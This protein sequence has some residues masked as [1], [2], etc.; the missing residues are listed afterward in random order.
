MQ[1]VA[2]AHREGLDAAA[3][4]VDAGEGVAAVVGPRGDQ[5]VLAGHPTS[6]LRD[7]A[8]HGLVRGVLADEVDDARTGHQ[9]DPGRTATAV[10]AR[11]AHAGV[12]A[13][14]LDGLQRDHA[15]W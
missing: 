10:A 15:A 14:C 7:R 1:S 4:L 13:G 6:G 9:R 12:D 11:V 3:E 8:A 5:V 2:A